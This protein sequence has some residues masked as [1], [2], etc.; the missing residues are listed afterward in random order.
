M[1]DNTISIGDIINIFLLMLT[2]VGLV[3]TAIELQQTKKINRAS[4][5]KELYLQLYD[6]QELREMF[7]KIEWSDFSPSDR[8][9]LGGTEEE[10]KAD[11]LLSFFEV[12]CNMYYRGV[13]TKEDMETFDYEMRRVYSHPAVK[14]YL[15]FLEAWQQTQ[16]IGKSYVAYKKY[17]S[18][19]S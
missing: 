16:S 6:D 4:L 2:V 3:F 15:Q 1:I 9:K 18:H 7:F 13:L 5:V 14:E 19:I 8:L 10:R 12:I 11:K 17:C